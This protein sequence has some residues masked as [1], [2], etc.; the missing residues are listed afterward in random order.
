MSYLAPF[1]RYG[2]LKSENVADFPTPSHSASPL[3]MLPLDVR[4]ATYQEET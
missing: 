1:R 4:G 2:E 3:R